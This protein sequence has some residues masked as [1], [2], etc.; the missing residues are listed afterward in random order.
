MA[1]RAGGRAKDGDSGEGD[2]LIVERLAVRAGKAFAPNR[3]RA[4]RAPSREYCRESDPPR[5]A[6]AIVNRARLL[7]VHRIRDTYA[8][9][10][11]KRSREFRAA[12]FPASADS[13][14]LATF[15]RNH[16]ARAMPTPSGQPTALRQ[17]HTPTDSPN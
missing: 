14:E 8:R 10:Q 4:P 16:A 3:A 11:S 2:A 1:T 9:W 12:F 7:V 13:R 6:T 5:T 15:L 17:R